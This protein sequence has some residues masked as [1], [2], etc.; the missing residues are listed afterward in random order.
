MCLNVIQ[1]HPTSKLSYVQGIRLEGRDEIFC[2][3]SG[4]V[5]K[6]AKPVRCLRR[7]R[8]HRALLSEVQAGG[9]GSQAASAGVTSR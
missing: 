2:E 4:P 6:T 3:S 1:A 8:R 5:P 9:A 7:I